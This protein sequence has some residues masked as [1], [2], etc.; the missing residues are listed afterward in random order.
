MYRNLT[1][2]KKLKPL[3]LHDNLEHLLRLIAFQLI[4]RKEQLG[5]AVF[6]LSSDGDSCTFTYFPKKSV[7]NLEQNPDSVAGLPFRILSCPM[8]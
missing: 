3:L 5:N 8:L 1:E 2:T 6:P 4:L 7:G